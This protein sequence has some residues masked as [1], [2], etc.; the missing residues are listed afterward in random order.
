MGLFFLGMFAI[1]LVLSFMG[2]LT[3]FVPFAFLTGGFFSG[4]S[5]YIGMS[6]ATSG[7]RAHGAGCQ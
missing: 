4:L 7:E 3:P 1:L 5:G 2:F 6:I